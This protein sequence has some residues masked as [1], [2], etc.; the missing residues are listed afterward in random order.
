MIKYLPL[1]FLLIS[2]TSVSPTVQTDNFDY[3]SVRK[4]LFDVKSAQKE[5]VNKPDTPL[6][7]VISAEISQRFTEAGYPVVSFTHGQSTNR[8]DP[9]SFSHV[10][11]GVIEDTRLTSTPAG[12]SFDFGNSSPQSP[13]FQKT[14]SAPITCK[15]TS[16]KDAR[17]E[18]ALKELKSITISMENF[19]DNSAGQQEKLKRFYIENIGSTCHNLLS[20]L[21][22]KPLPPSALDNNAPPDET[23]APAVRVETKYKTDT[24]KLPQQK[25]YQLDN[26]ETTRETIK[27]KQLNKA[28][29]KVIKKEQLP[30]PVI[31]TEKN[32]EN[33]APDL[34]NKEITIFNQGDTVILEF[35]H[36]RR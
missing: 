9:A 34:R 31:V 21:Q 36:T 1:P 4:I 30:P 19:T 17:Q 28:A 8:N 27:Q 15:L 2:C 32:K 26:S 7:S 12:F 3:K 14:L 29:D 16:Q 6:L 5:S 13:N 24:P 35:G 22:I 18:V 20:R 11:E 33:S 23:F 10:M 25:Q